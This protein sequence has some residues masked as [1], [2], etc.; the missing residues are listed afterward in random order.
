MNNNPIGV[1]DSGI[2]GLTVFSKLSELLP[3]ENFIYFGDTANMPYGT[4]SKE[5]LL[6]I[7][8]KI[9]DFFAQKNVKAVVM[10]CNTTSAVAYDCLKHDYNF[11]M[12]PLI[13]TVCKI[14]ANINANKIGVLSTEATANSHAYKMYLKKYNPNI[15]V[16]EHGCPGKW[17][18]CVESGSQSDLT[19]FEIIKNHL[20]ILLNQNVQKIIL[21]CTH[22][23]YLKNILVNISKKDIFIDPSEYFAQYI[24]NDLEQSGNKAEKQLFKPEFYVSSNPEQ[25]FISSKIFYNI[26]TVPTL[27]C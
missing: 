20:N 19:N 13:Q 22:Y 2:G 8:H 27:A 10:A 12:Y 1:Y 4:K 9:M 3:N 15:D 5:D 11:I 21:G 6:K 17:V 24:A 16:I 25:F 14:L 23:P 18:E 7:T 26:N